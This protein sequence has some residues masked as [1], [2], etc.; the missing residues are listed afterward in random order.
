MEAGAIEIAPAVLY[1]RQDARR[2][3]MRSALLITLLICSTP[4]WA[5]PPEIGKA[6]PPFSL[7]DR[8]GALVSL[9]DLAYPGDERPARPKQVVVL[10][11]FR[12]DCKPCLRSLP[13]LVEL[14]K[15]LLGK[16]VKVILV[17]LL[18]EEEGHEKLDRLLGQQRLPF[19]VLIDPYAAAGKKYVAKNGGFEIP[20]L[21]VIDRGGVLRSRTQGL[22][23]E[24]YPKLTKLIEELRK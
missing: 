18:E 15:K 2:W 16:R 8:E 9:A 14:H 10:D 12:T 11:F 23:P 3:T 20:S 6:A 19:L 24:S 4:G 21:F 5:A 7:R 13:K 1:H 22:T 17:A